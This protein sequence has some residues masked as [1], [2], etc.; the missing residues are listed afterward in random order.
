MGHRDGWNVGMG[1]DQAEEDLD[2]RDTIV[3][4]MVT[5]TII[6]KLSSSSFE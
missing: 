6:R 3:E 5:Y 1:S 4:Q 2:Q